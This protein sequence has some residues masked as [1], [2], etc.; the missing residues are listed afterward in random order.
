MINLETHK[1]LVIARARHVCYWIAEDRGTKELLGVV[2]FMETGSRMKGFRLALA[3]AEMKL[4][5]TDSSTSQF[6]NETAEN[7]VPLGVVLMKRLFILMFVAFAFS[8]LMEPNLRIVEGTS[9]TPESRQQ[10][11][12]HAFCNEQ[13]GIVKGWTG[14]DRNSMSDAQKDADAHNKQ[15]H[16]GKGDVGVL[17]E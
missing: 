14:P 7:R 16:E 13:H 12:C 17:C 5:A 1:L 8:S 6:T 11:K 10:G 9:L 2:K 15:Y 3:F 4:R